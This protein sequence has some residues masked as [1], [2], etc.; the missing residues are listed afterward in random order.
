M[1]GLVAFELDAGAV[2]AIAA[3]LNAWLA[4]PKSRRQVAQETLVETTRELWSWT[5]VAKVVIDASAGEL[6]LIPL[7]PS[8]V[9]PDNDWRLTTTHRMAP[10]VLQTPANHESFN[11]RQARWSDVP[12]R[13]D[14]VRDHADP[15][16][17]RGAASTAAPKIDTLLD[18]MIVLSSFVFAVVMVMMGYCIWRYRAKP[19]D[20]SD[21]EP[22]HGNT[23]LEIVWT[24][25][26]TVI[27]LVCAGY[28]WIILD[29]IEASEN[30]MTIQSPPSS[31][32]GRSTTPTRGSH[33]TSCTS[34]SI[35]RSSSR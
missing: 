5:G 25:I 10:P 14:H 33:R 21:G 13:D 24:L 18:V 9:N 1:A 30:P 4:L 23:R 29:D 31:S 20:E 27:V 35:S 7:V 17:E 15:R 6:G 12:A 22:I 34:R 2:E 19:G 32:S 26:P 16:L 28:S 11:S 8:G 3:R